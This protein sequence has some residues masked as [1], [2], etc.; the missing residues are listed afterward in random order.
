MFSLLVNSRRRLLVA[1]IALTLLATAP[2][3]A[4]ET[5][6]QPIAVQPTAEVGSEQ[7]LT[8]RGAAVL[9]A[10]ALNLGDQGWQGLFS[11]VGQGSDQAGII[12]ALALAG[13][14]KGYPDGAFRPDEA[15][16][17]GRFASWMAQGFLTG[18][19][20]ADPVTFADV[21]AEATYA[22][23][24]QKLYGAG[25]TLGCSA[26]PLMFCGEDILTHREADILLER[27][28]ALPYLVSNCQD[29]GPW[30]LLCNVHEYID[31]E[32]VLEVTTQDMVA[33]IAQAVEQI[34]TEVGE[35]GPKRPQFVCSIPD[36]LFEPACAWAR[37]VPD[38]PLSQ[39]VES[40]VRAVIGGLDPNSAYHDPEEWRAIKEAGR[41]V[42]IGVRVVTVDENWQ[43][44]CA[45]LSATCRILILTVFEGGP[46][47]KAGIQ[48]GDYIVAVDGESLDGMTLGEAAGIIRGEIDTSVDITIVRHD[49]EHRLTLIRQEIVVPYTSAAFHATDSI[50]YIELTSFGA[51]PGGAVQEFRERVAEAQGAELL[52]LDLRN[53]GGGSVNV[54]QGIAGA[55][56]GD[57]PVMTFHTV[58]ESYDINGEGEILLGE[59][60][61]LVV[62][63]NGFSASAS[64]VLAGLLSETGRGVIMGETTF[65]KNTGQSLIDLFNQGVFRLTTIRW[66]TPDGIDIG[67]NGVPLDIEIEIPN[68]DIQ[69]LMEWVKSTLDN[70]PEEAPEGAE[71]QPEQ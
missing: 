38:A 71:D 50:A 37:I 31:T 25:I 10:E 13:V 15:I 34:M 55:L 41:Y 44:G 52:I 18:G 36:P 39:V 63:V 66:T 24:V 14:V 58:E 62:L 65:M 16:S 53:N 2:V 19:F 61:R 56:V 33:P 42:G 43:P 20:V 21:P 35:E 28:L 40:V 4:Q 8:A 48:R 9:I 57:V 12:E 46:A 70:P 49:V 22:D 27:A 45:P 32:Y 11:D 30:L 64:E 7:S 60:T 29:P 6:A 67:E 17:R 23:A 1:L 26:A 51:F 3:G 68:T 47:E 54:L 5:H 69:G 59:D